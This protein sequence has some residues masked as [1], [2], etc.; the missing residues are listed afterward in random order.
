MKEE[1]LN[2]GYNTVADILKKLGYSLQL[3]QKMLQVS[4]PVISIDA[5]KKNWWEI[6]RKMGKI[7]KNKKKNRKVKKPKDSLF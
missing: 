1:R 4:E 5:K 6:S 2:I 7:S 3:N